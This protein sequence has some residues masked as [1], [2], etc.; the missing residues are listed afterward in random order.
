W[1]CDRQN[2][3]TARVAVNHM[4]A[5]HFGRPLVE[6]PQDFGVRTKPPAQQALLDWLAVEFMAHNWS[7]KWMHRLMVTSA[8]YRME[9]SSRDSRATENITTDPENQFYWRMNPRRMEAEV[10]RDAL[11][12]LSGELDA[13]L[14][15]PPLDC[16]TGTDSPRRSLYYRYSR[17]DKMDFLTTFD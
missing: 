6:N 10:V 15:G 7:L 3:L 13:T 4:W 16:R 17:D 9:S 1:L 11:L 14:G 8:A 2:P 5:R 12:Y